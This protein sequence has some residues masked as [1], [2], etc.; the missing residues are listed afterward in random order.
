MPP[1][2][3]H[4]TAEDQV[5]GHRPAALSLVLNLLLPGL[6]SAI[7]GNP[8]FAIGIPLL[9]LTCILIVCRLGLP[10]TRSGLAI[11]AVLICTLYLAGATHWATRPRKGARLGQRVLT[12]LTLLILLVAGALL[13]TR[14]HGLLGYRIYLIPSGSMQPALLPGDLILV[15]LATADATPPALGRIVTFSLGTEPTTYV[16]RVSPKPQRLEHSAVSK[17]YVLGDNPDHSTDS[18]SFGLIEKNQ[19]SGEVKMV[20]INLLSGDRLLLETH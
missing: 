14:W 3:S 20:L 1:G 8:S 9:M 12:V 7:S 16:K 10:D 18:R 6:G 17:L 4:R 13:F 2:I 19:V 11:L 15:R 5:A